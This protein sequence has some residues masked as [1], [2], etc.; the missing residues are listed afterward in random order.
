M[1]LARRYG[2]V[3]G[4]DV[5]GFLRFV[6]RAA[7]LGADPGEAVVVDEQLDAVRLMTVHG[8]KGQEFP[9]VVVADCSNRGGGGQPAVLISQDGRRVGM[10]CAPDGLGLVNGFAYKELCDADDALGDEEERRITYVAMTRAQRHLS[11]IGR[12]YWRADGTR[13]W[14]GPMAWIAGSLPAAQVPAIGQ[15]AR[16]RVGDSSVSVRSVLPDVGSAGI[17]S[18]PPALVEAGEPPMVPVPPPRPTPCEVCA[19]ATR[20]SNCARRARSDTTS[21]SS[22]ASRRQTA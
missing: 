10:R 2:Q 6:H 3:R 16:V 22:L 5:R 13:A 11:A 18:G 14:D 8:A 12:A 17:T 7:D 1:L 15:A 21:R 9:A 20:R 4:A 19:S